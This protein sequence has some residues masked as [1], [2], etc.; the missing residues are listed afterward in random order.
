MKVK[1]AAS[2][3]KK[4]GKVIKKEGEMFEG[5]NRHAG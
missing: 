4:R 5:R 2:K 1:E 3:K